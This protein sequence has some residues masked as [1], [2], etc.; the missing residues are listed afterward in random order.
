MK[1]IITML[2][3]LCM[4][5]STV[6]CSSG[7]NESSS[8]SDSNSSEAQTSSTT[9]EKQD[10][11]GLQL[12]LTDETEELT[13]WCVYNNNAVPN[14]NDLKG[15]QELERR[16]N[17][18]INW[19]PVTTS[20]ASEKQGILF[21]SGDLPDIMYAAS[22]TYP[23]GLAKGVEDGV[24]ADM[25]PLIREYMPNYMAILNSN[26]VAR[27]Q[28]TSD[29]DKLMAAYVMVGTDTTI[30]SEGTWNG[31]AYRKDL[32]DPMGLELPETVS[33]WHDVL[34]KAKENG[35]PAPFSPGTN[36][37]SNLSL[38]Y[39]VTTNATDN[40]LQLDGDTV[41]AS[42]LQDGFGQ[43]LEEMRSW[44]SEG[45][46]DPNFTSGGPMV[47]RDYSGVENDSTL[48]YDGWYAFACGNT[49]YTMGQTTNPD[50]YFQAITNP[51]LKPGDE[52]VQ[53]SQ[54]II[55][56]DPIYITTA[57]E[58]PEL[59]AQWLDYWWSDEG[60]YLSWYGIEGETYELDEKGTPEFTEL[61]TNNPDGLAPSDVLYQ[62]AFNSGSWF[63]K[64]D[65]EQGWKMANIINNSEDNIQL[66]STAIFSAPE[67]NLWL[68]S[69]LAFTDAEGVELTSLQTA[70]NTLIEEYMVNYMFGSGSMSVKEWERLQECLFG[71]KAQAYMELAQVK[72]PEDIPR[73][74][75][76][77]HTGMVGNRALCEL[78]LRAG[79]APAYLY[80]FDHDLPGNNDGSFHSSELW[81]VF[82][83]FERCWRPMTG[84]DFELSR[85]MTAY[86]ANFAKRKNPNG[87]KLP[88]WKPY[89][90]TDREN[91]LFQEKPHC[92]QVEENPLQAFVLK[93]IMED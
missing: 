31:L 12:P 77:T 52:P 5:A 70:V 29:E 63:G 74:I 55:A 85:A 39:G 67:T 8:V 90:E 30:E 19:I 86:W 89:T 92:E 44:F 78:V 11:G 40:Y 73:V 54:R 24:I 34:L 22:F 66:D 59:A 84:T 57:C 41:V 81:Y 2:L 69:S 23:G 91:M 7:D 79:H 32:F 26:E 3:A 33:E 83:T 14:P 49:T 58:K 72:E 64:H 21:S 46:I 10:V 20:E 93:Y 43:Y 9:V 88:T 71:N 82:G 51:V 28:A 37:G 27:R 38:A 17:V 60:T 16:T 4:M 36:G 75:K 25:D 1:K 65:V 15:V 6:A 48:L 61:V 42:A 45:L 53:C 56:K 13:V 76:D 18:H 68:T 50:L 35:M 80:V 87:E 47:T 62:Y